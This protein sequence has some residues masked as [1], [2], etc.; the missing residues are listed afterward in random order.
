MCLLRMREKRTSRDRATTEK[1]KKIHQSLWLLS[2]NLLLKPAIYRDSSIP[3][4][5]PHALRAAQRLIFLLFDPL[6]N[7]SEH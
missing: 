3:P 6:Q 7:H 1:K 4:V 2:F 5:H